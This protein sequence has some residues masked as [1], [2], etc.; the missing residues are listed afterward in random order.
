MK[1]LPILW[2]RLVSEGKT[3]PRCG[4][5]EANVSSAVRKLEMV[6]A[7]LGIRPELTAQAIDGVAFR[8][9]PSESNR[10]WIGG[11]PME[12]WLGGRAGHTRCC[13]VCG[14]SPCRTMEVD[15]Q[16]YEALPEQQIIRAAMVAAAAMLGAPPA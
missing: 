14:D 11:E 7:P 2:K 4:A 13:E 10:I 3:C 1:P 9:A 8:S 6:L 15:G 12:K 5:T 16:V